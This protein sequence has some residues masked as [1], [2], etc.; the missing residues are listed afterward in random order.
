[1]KIRLLKQNKADYGILYAKHINVFVISFYR[2]ALQISFG[3][4]PFDAIAYADF[5]NETFNR[6]CIVC[7]K[8]LNVRNI[9]QQI[10]YHKKCRKYRH[11][12]RIVQFTK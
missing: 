4:R 7:G 8:P 10:S 1:M 6:N 11:A 3:N 2:Y 9:G 5:L 12:K